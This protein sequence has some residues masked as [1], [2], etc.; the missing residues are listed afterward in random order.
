MRFA[1]PR[2]MIS[3]HPFP[4]LFPLIAML[5]VFA[6]FPLAAGHGDEDP[7]CTLDD[8]QTPDDEAVVQ[9]NARKRSELCIASQ[10]YPDLGDLHRAPPLTLWATPYAG[11]TVL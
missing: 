6:V 2:F 9:R 11:H 10:R 4:W 1:V 7:A 5:L 8:F 3:E